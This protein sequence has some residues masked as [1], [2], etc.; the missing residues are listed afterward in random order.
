VGAAAGAFGVALFGAGAA[1]GPFGV[2][3]FGAGAAAGACEV[4]LVAAGAAAVTATLVCGE[5]TVVVACQMKYPA[6]PRTT[7]AASQRMPPP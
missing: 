7:K 2:A 1:A 6:P 4:V 3:L 5:G